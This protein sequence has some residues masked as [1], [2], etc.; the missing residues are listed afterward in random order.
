MTTIVGLKFVE[1]TFG[2]EARPRV[3][4]QIDT[5]GHS[6]AMA[7]IYSMVLYIIIYSCCM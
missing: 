4:W 6:S 3:A 5:F 7:S 2:E 1:D